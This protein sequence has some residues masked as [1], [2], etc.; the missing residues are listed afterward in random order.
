M[1]AGIRTS[2]GANS[3]S[4]P[5]GSRAREQ[6]R[7][8]ATRTVFAPNGLRRV[9]APN[10]VFVAAYLQ[11]VRAGR[12]PVPSEPCCLPWRSSGVK[13]KT[14]V[15]C[16]L[17]EMHYRHKSRGDLVRVLALTLA[18]WSVLFAAQALT[19]SHGK[20]RSE[21]AC[22]VCQA[23]HVGVPIAGPELLS[24]PLFV[25][26]CVQ[27]FLVTIHLELFFHDSSSRAPPTK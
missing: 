25:A 24:S 14:R 9:R 11:N 10:A 22:H 18:V 17:I 19:H 26:G 2:F 20:A 21:A 23:A 27:P 7:L 4:D 15:V 16:E 6:K 12:W 5:R 3:R 1:Q 13:A 8:A